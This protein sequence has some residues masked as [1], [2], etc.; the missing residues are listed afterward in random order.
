MTSINLPLVHKLSSTPIQDLPPLLLSLP[1]PTLL[2]I[3]NYLDDLYY[4]TDTS[5]FDDTRYDILKDILSKNYP[6]SKG[7]IGTKLREGTN[8]TTLPYWLGSANKI[9]DSISLDKWLTKHNFPPLIISEKLDGV[10]CLL[11][12][13]D[14]KLSLYT[15]G[16]GTV[17]A[18]ISHLAPYIRLPSLSSPIAVRGELIIPTQVFQ[19]KYK[20]E[21]RNPRNM[22]SGLVGAKSFRQ[23]LNDINFI[24][25][26]IIYS[27]SPTSL[28]PSQQFSKLAQTGF[29]TAKYFSLSTP[30]SL[31][32]L[33]NLF[34]ETK[35]TSLYELDG[36]IV[37][38]DT[39]YTRN[40]SGNPDYLFAF[41]TR[42]EED[43]YETVVDHIEWNTSKWG[44]LKPVAVVKPVVLHS[45]TLSRATA[46]NAKYVVSNNLGKG[47]I[48]T[49][50]RSNDVIPYI[51]NVLSPTSPDLPQVPYIWDKNEVNIISHQDLATIRIK[52]LS[53]FFSKLGIKYVSEATVQKLINNGLDT[54]IKI[55]QADKDRL[56][57]VPEFQD[58]SA[59]R[60]YTNIKQGLTGIKLSTFLGASSVLGY[61]IGRRKVETLLNGIPDILTIYKNKS[62]EELISLICDVQGF[63]VITATKIANNLK[64]ADTLIQKT[65]DYVSFLSIQKTS[66]SLENQKIVMSGFR[67]KRLEDSIVQAGGKVTTTVSGNTTGVIV[68]DK[69]SESSKVEKA[70]ELGIPIYDKEEFCTKFF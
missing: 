11:I 54:F 25:Y 27:L 64:Y 59:E 51:T 9:T 24:P 38:A 63:S 37:Q 46:H 30:P 58:K 18:D 35:N 40:T 48:I 21:Y 41:K 14:N 50:T 17:G 66:S 39:P 2:S 33:T 49:V 47:S 53:D 65:K 16:D 52:I 5:F 1:T 43:S 45:I 7:Q 62:K 22:V 32:S 57:Q 4:N 31:T 67:D 29:Q 56:L 44:Y 23:G 19:E 42:L 36:L 3:K 70:R 69:N 12:Y 61:G 20:N 68:V 13:K 26:E 60:I 28:R 10:S 34:L 15:R 8:R 6:V 55:I